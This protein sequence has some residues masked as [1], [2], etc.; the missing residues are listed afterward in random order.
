[1]PYPANVGS[2]RLFQTKAAADCERR[3]D[4]LIPARTN[5]LWKS[6]AAQFQPAQTVVNLTA[7]VQLSLRS[8]SYKTIR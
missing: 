5:R 7:L 3:I 2:L 1:V 4:A 6:N 8:E